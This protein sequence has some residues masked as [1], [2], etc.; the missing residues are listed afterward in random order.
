MRAGRLDR[1]ALLQQRTLAA[2]DAYGQKVASYSTLA[3]V[4]VDR[5]DIT[6]REFYASAQVHA[7]ASTRFTLR[8][9]SGL[10]SVNRVLCEG[11]IYDVLH[12]AELGRRDWLELTCKSVM[13]A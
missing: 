11:V 2:P 4:W 1:L 3:T 13:P 7:D 6:G 8:Y 10:T 9:L 5:K 12:V